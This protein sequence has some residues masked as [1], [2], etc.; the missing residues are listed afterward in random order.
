MIVYFYFFEKRLFHLPSTTSCLTN[1][2]SGCSSTP[3]SLTI[4]PAF[5]SSKKITL[6]S[7]CAADDD[8]DV[9]NFFSFILVFCL[10]WM[11]V[12]FSNR[13]FCK[14]LIV[15]AFEIW[16]RDIPCLTVSK[17]WWWPRNKIF[18]QFIKVYEVRINE[19]CIINNIMQK[20]KKKKEIKQQVL[21]HTARESIFCYVR[22]QPN[23]SKL[24]PGNF[25][26]SFLRST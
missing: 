25:L 15:V 3:S 26:K 13:R 23:H 18:R 14:R 1:S 6:L 9:V 21:H 24:P 8:D 19:N 20:K 22:K 4:L 7:T 11:S 16:I 17:C 2:R 12:I 10:L 5:K